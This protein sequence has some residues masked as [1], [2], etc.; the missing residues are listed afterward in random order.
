MIADGLKGGGEGDGGEVEAVPEGGVADGC[1]GG[2]E[3]E[4]GERS[5]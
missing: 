2:G 3:G 1:D 5:Y 4:G